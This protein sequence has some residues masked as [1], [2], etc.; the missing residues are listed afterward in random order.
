M[1]SKNIGE[2]LDPIFVN[3]EKQSQ[4]RLSLPAKVIIQQGFISIEMDDLGM[5]EYAG[6]RNR[7]QAIVDAL[8]ELPNFLKYLEAMA[9]NR[10]NTEQSSKIIGG[11][12]VLQHA[13]KWKDLFKCPCWPV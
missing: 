3:F 7:D 5:G 10:P 13:K 1:A 6:G 8:S 11:I 12:F 9:S 2:Q 4:W